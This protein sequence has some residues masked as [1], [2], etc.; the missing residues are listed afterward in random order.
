[1]QHAAGIRMANHYLA[2]SSS[3]SHVIRHILQMVLFIEVVR[4]CVA[5]SDIR[6]QIGEEVAVGILA[7]GGTQRLVRSEQGN[8]PPTNA[9]EEASTSVEYSYAPPPC[10][11][12]KISNKDWCEQACVEE[13]NTLAELAGMVP[14]RCVDEGYRYKTLETIVQIFAPATSDLPELS[15]YQFPAH[16]NVHYYIKKG[17]CECSC[18]GENSDITSYVEARDGIK[19]G[20]CVDQEYTDSVT[21]SKYIGQSNLSFYVRTP[22]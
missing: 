17:L 12:R 20:L 14:G 18:V 3:A 2:F 21:Y 19:P 5:L 7:P 6:Q 22:P 16:C 4:H 8:A 9:T 10:D 1:M 13:N 15:P 11:D